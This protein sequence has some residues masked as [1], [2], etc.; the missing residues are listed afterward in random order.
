MKRIL[1]TLILLLGA[2]CLMAQSW[3]DMLKKAATEVADKV[4][5]GKLTAASLNG[6]WSY[7]A[8]AIKLESSNALNEIGSTA[9]ESIVTPKLERAYAIV[10]LKAGAGRFTFNEDKSFTAALGRAKNL[11]GTYEFDP[12]TH[13]LTLSFAH[14]KFKLGKVSGKA[15]ISGNE[16]QLV[17][18]V[19]KLVEIVTKLGSSIASLNTIASLLES[20]D[21]VYLGFGF[22]RS[23]TNENS[24]N[25]IN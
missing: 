10:G 15:Y 7:T 24:H 25:S 22:S 9:V 16:L 1:F 23:T 2:E 5:G 14:S 19:T 11:G 12:E 13:T 18:P 3:S 17:F 20:Y 21:D 6:S 8:P 4:T